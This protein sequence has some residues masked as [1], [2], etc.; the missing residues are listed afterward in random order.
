MKSKSGAASSSGTDGCH[1]RRTPTCR[2]AAGPIDRTSTTSDKDRIRNRP[3]DLRP[4][5]DRAA[6]DRR[7]RRLLQHHGGTV[8]RLKHVAA[9][10]ARKERL[11]HGDA[12]AVLRRSRTPG[13]VGEADTLRTRRERYLLA[14]GGRTG[15]QGADDRALALRHND[16]VFDAAHYGR[17]EIR[18]AKEGGNE[19]AARSVVEIFGPPDLRNQPLVHDGDAVGHDEGFFLVVRHVDECD[20]EISMKAA[21]LKLQV[22]AELL[23]E[24]P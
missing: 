23:V 7:T 14:R 3:G 21:H 6:P 16:I 19:A 10:L 13:A 8:A 15:R 11:G 9:A 2:V 5:A 12:E 24:R 18:L 17:Q 4:L 22:L 20:A 1:D